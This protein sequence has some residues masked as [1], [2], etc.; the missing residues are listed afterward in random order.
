[1]FAQSA[2][3]FRVSKLWQLQVEDREE[4]KFERQVV[5]FRVFHSFYD[6][7]LHFLV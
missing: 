4:L 5:N 6:L 3:W 2:V 7:T 1:M